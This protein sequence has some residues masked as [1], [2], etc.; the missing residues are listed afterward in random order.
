VKLECAKF[1]QDI[2]FWAEFQTGIK[3]F[4]PWMKQAEV[5]K[6][7]GITKPASLEQ[8]TKI[9]ED[10]KVQSNLFTLLT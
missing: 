7:A 1:S 6:A 2:K 4:A 10:S 9:L 3:E 8:A 5:R